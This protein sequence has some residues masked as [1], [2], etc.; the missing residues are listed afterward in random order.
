MTDRTTLLTLAAV[1]LI[2]GAA[3]AQTP[4]AAPAAADAAIA[5][6][7]CPK[8]G[9]VPSPTLASDNQRRTWQREYTA[10]GECMKKFISDQRALAEPHNKAANAA[11]DDYNTAVAKY[12]EQ[13][14]KLKEG[15]K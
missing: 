3:H 10:W 5:K 1:A 11:I 13:V 9:D 15:A 7:N 6:P 12:N 2:A 14:D 8:P 4:A